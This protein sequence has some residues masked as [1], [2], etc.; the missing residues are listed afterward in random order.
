MNQRLFSVF[1]SSAS[2]VSTGGSASA[3]A[4]TVVA[5]SSVLVVLLIRIHFVSV[6]RVLCRGSETAPRDGTLPS[7]RV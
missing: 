2:V 3:L 1:R 4:A 7:R 5:G 6:L